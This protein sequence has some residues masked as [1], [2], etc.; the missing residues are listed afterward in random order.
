MM[1]GIC[2]VNSTASNRNAPL[3]L[4]T[5][6]S[7]HVGKRPNERRRARNAQVALQVLQV[8]GSSYGSARSS[9][10]L[11]S[12]L[13]AGGKSRIPQKYSLPKQ[14]STSTHLQAACGHFMV[15][16]PQHVSILRLRIHSP[17]SP[18]CN[19]HRRKPQYVTIPPFCTTPRD[20]M[21]PVRI[22]PKK[23]CLV[24]FVD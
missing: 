23:E 4:H 2:V 18:L 15:H 11:P 5:W 12:V 19:H 3:L 16:S 6:P 9:L 13:N 14:E 21:S 20:E 8:L 22:F 10:S 24:M 7:A 1:C 17:Q